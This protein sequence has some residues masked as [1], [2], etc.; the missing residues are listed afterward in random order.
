MSNERVCLD[1]KDKEYVPDGMC[2]DADDNLWVATFG[3]SKVLHINPTSGEIL[4]KIEFPCPNI[5]S[6]C[7]GGENL[8]DL[9]VTSAR[10]NT[11]TEKFPLAGSTWVI[12]NMPFKGRESV[13]YR[14]NN[15]K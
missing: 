14:M 5:T 11:D 15:H 8:N 12:K 6:C 2:I 3:G 1:F 10:I 13:E 9:Y 4:G 7:F